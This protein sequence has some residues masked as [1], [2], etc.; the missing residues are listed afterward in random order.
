MVFERLHICTFVFKEKDE[1]ETIC[2]IVC[3]PVIRMLEITIQGQTVGDKS[4]QQQMFLSQIS[5]TIV[6]LLPH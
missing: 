5:R 1:Y 2:I 4:P 6:Y 3:N